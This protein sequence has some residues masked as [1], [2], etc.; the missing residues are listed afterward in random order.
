MR[1]ENRRRSKDLENIVKRFRMRMCELVV[2]GN[3]D[4][5]LRFDFVS[6]ADNGRP[7]V[8]GGTC[9]VFSA[10]DTP[11]DVAHTLRCMGDSLDEYWANAF[12]TAA[13]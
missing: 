1:G 2:D 10:T 8:A 11:R 12:P 13:H 5:V 7:L 3:G 6:I 4:R 9:T